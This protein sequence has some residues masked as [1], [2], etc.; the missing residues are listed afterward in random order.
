L[1]ME[2]LYDAINIV[3]K[4]KIKHKE[5]ELKFILYNELLVQLF[6]MRENLVLHISFKASIKQVFQE[7]SGM[8]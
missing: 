6:E 8:Q 1:N 2:D 5:G 7:I 4:Y 3:N